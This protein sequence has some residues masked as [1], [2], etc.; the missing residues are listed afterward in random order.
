MTT[1]RESHFLSAFPFYFRDMWI[2]HAMYCATT[3]SIPSALFGEFPSLTPAILPAQ[4]DSRSNPCANKCSRSLRCKE[5]MPI[6]TRQPLI[7]FCLLLS[8]RTGISRSSQGG[9]SLKVTLNPFTKPISRCQED[10]PLFRNTLRSVFASHFRFAFER[11]AVAYKDGRQHPTA[12]LISRSFFR[13]R[14]GSA[15][16]YATVPHFPRSPLASHSNISL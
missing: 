15:H 5:D 10:T 4:T 8:F 6:F 9:R 2:R 12:K 7:V 1:K 11:V 16:I 14:K 13:H 3:T